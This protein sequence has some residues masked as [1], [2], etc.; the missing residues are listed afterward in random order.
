MPSLSPYSQRKRTRI[1]F[2]RATSRGSQP[3]EVGGWGGGGNGE[4]MPKCLLSNSGVSRN[5]PKWSVKRTSKRLR[6]DAGAWV[7]SCDL[8]VAIGGVILNVQTNEN[9]NF[10]ERYE[11]S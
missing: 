10:N 11:L 4:R 3:Q 5:L 8:S 2:G 9:Y 7:R 1:F 6:K